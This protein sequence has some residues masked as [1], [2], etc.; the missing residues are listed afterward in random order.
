MPVANSSPVAKPGSRLRELGLGWIEDFRQ[1]VAR[2]DVPTLIIHGD[3]DRVVPFAASGQ[4][5][6]KLIKGA[7]LLVIKGGPHCITWTH[8]DEVN[9]GL[10]DFIQS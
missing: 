2:I 10:L 3:E 9:A 4:R 6:A 7:R 5:T 1:D 8:A